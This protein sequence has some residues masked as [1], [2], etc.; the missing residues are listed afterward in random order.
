[1]NDTNKILSRPLL[2]MSLSLALAVGSAH[3]QAP[4][5]AGPALTQAQV[6]ALL[7][8]QGYTK[9]DKLKF[10]DGLWKTEATSGDGKR[11]DVRVGARGGRIYAE[12]VPS[13]LSEAEVRAALTTAGYTQ[14]HDV[15]YDDGLWQAQA[16]SATGE[17]VEVYA[18]PVDGRVVSAERD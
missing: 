3:A 18:D 11:G 12:G 2:A 1:M 14:V 10:E 6:K 8:E 13:K 16:H 4:A 15:K 9:L 7:S 5:P 17:R